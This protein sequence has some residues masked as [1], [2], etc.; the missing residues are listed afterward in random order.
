VSTA[1][2]SPR[3]DHKLEGRIALG[4]FV[5]LA[6]LSLWLLTRG[7][8]N[9]NLPGHEFRQTQTALSALFIQR[10][11]SL[12]LAYPTP[13]LGAPWAVPM[14]F[15]LYQWMVVGVSNATGWPIV[16]AGRA[17]SAFGWYAAIAALWPLLAR[18]GLAWPRRLVVMGL[19]LTCPLYLFYARS[20]LIET[21]ELA[22]AL[23]FLAAFARYIAGDRLRWLPVVAA[24]GVLAGVVKVT[25]FIVFL[26]PAGALTLL[27]MWRARGRG[28][29]AVLKVAGW[30]VAAIV[31]PVLATVQWTHFADA[32]KTL[33][34]S[35]H[36]LRSANAASF[37][38]GTMENRF[39][40]ETLAGHWRNITHGIV[41]PWVLLAGLGLAATVARRLW[42]PVAFCAVCYVLP[43]AIFPTLYA[44]HD[45]YSVANAVLLLAAL[46]VAVTALLD[47]R[48][49]W[50]A[51][52]VVLAVHG[53]QLALF[54]ANYLPMQAGA[55]PGGSDMTKAVRLMTDPDES[56]VVAGYDWDSAVAFYSQRRALMIRM[57]MERD[58]TY[59]HEAFKAQRG[60]NF[61]VFVGRGNHREDSDLLRLLGEYFQIDPRPLFRWADA[62]VYA[63]GDRRGVMVDA[64]RRG[65]E[66]LHNV[67]L[68]PSTAAEDFVIV[69]RERRTDELLLADQEIMALFEPRPWRFYHQFGSGFAVEEGRKVLL[70]HPDTRLWFREPKGSVVVRVECGLMAGAY[71]DSVPAPDRSDGVEFYVD[72]ERSDG[73]R[74]RLA[75]LL[76][77]PATDPRD[78]GFHVLEVPATVG[79]GESIIVGNNGGPRGSMARDWAAI[80]SIRIRPAG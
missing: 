73:T 8:H 51:W 29:G 40:S 58:W 37:T 43:L 10:D 54:R 77:E 57:G 14:E 12:S 33:N 74:E 3:V 80:A 19:V 26:I 22:L 47:G 7:W 41:S 32:V 63:R 24:L 49:P 15:P 23:W 68:D 71:A 6:A 78:R 45:Y 59:L 70:V 62:T 1:D 75:S 65:G 55:S 11:G 5:A 60:Q 16:Q 21:T 46:G 36:F 42:R 64:L 69:D 25:T 17:V 30:G 67:V 53:M 35:A 66:R 39:A 18:L 48:R 38:F 56:I 4:L 79:E 13:I 9:G 27:E 34:P 31:L 20:F 44:W 2:A 28:R 72:R 50:I 76:L 61:T 52:V